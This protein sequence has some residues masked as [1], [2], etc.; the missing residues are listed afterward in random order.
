[1]IGI[2]GALEEELAILKGAM[3]HIE[4]ARTACFDFVTGAL[5]GREVVLLRCG[6]GKVQA[7]AGATALIMRYAP[8]V[9]I[10]TGCA[11]GVTPA[12]AV[13]LNFGD[14]VIGDQLVYH[15]V[16][17]TVF[18]YA[19]GQLPGHS[20]AY[21]SSPANLVNALERAVVAAREAGE[22]PAD[23][24]AIPGLIASADTFMADSQKI[25]ALQT[26]FPGVRAVEMEG[27]AIAHACA[28]FDVPCAVLRCLSDIAGEE[29]T[30]TYDEYL[31]AA[32]RNSSAIIRRFCSSW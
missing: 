15:D 20:S 29:S 22:V 27:T 12:G 16:D 26:V 11:G 23:F 7:A 5:C 21:F 30:V 17:V 24:K 10:N 9:V 19:M 13:P 2:I 32:A 31:P 6:V 14:A 8:E 3:E 18:G 25:L 1:M 4:T 28:L